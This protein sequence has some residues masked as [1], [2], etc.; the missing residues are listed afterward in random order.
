[1]SAEM[2][3][4][5]LILAEALVALRIFSHPSLVEEDEHPNP[6]LFVEKV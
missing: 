3:L 5:G 4:V 6:D 1:M 2:D